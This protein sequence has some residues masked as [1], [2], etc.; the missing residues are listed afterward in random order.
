Q[1]VDKNSCSGDFGGPVLYQT[2]SGYYQ[3]V[4]INS[5]KN[6]ECLP[7]SGIV[8]TKTANYVDNFIKSNTQDAQWCPAP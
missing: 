2:P 4:G 8:A 7:N 3:E 6:G 5:Y 1:P